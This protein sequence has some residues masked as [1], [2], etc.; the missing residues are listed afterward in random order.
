MKFQSFFQK[1]RIILFALCLVG[2]CVLGFIIPLRPT[3]SASEQRTLTSFPTFS[4]ESFWNGDYTSGVNLWYSDTF[5]FREELIGLNNTLRGLYGLKGTTAGSVVGGDSINTD[6]TFVWETDPVEPD[7]ESDAGT[8][9]GT[10]SS[11]EP[12]HEV[13]KGYLV[14]GING[15]ELYSFHR[16]NSNRYAK[17]VVQTALDLQGKAQVYCI[18]VPMSYAYGVSP[19]VQVELGASDCHEAIRYMYSAMAGYGA[20]AG[21]TTPVVTLDVFDH[22]A[23]HYDE[24]IYF[25]TDHHWTAKGA[26]YTSRVFL[27]AVGRTYPDLDA[28]TVQEITGFTGSLAGH[29]MQENPSLVRNP[30]TIYAYVS[31][32][33]NTVTITTQAGEVKEIPIVH[34]EPRS[35]YSQ[36]SLYKCFIDGDHPLTVAH[37][38][39][40]GDGSAILLIKESYG[41]AFLP[42]LV[43]SY[44][45]VVAVDYRYLR[46]KAI[47]DLVDEYGVDTVL[48]LNNPVATSADYNLY[49]LEKL[50]K[51]KPAAKPSE[52][53]LTTP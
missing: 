46:N 49:W 30:D 27:D 53:A 26:Y 5:P 52:P 15:Y 50:V 36:W 38:E 3:E 4:F 2:G 22:L 16:D 21:L 51:T 13:I 37:N 17:L 6:D 7:T 28:Y 41:N 35:L 8:E 39:A 33:L 18:V 31:P 45:Y 11:E 34:P 29:T 48:F 42:A 43:D 9:P 44:E 47:S 24:Y 10:E 32:T 12:G 14:D 23:D 1:L 19:E 40:V 20:S 25:R